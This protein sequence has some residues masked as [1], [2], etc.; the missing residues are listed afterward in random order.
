MSEV[1]LHASRRLAGSSME[2]M[3]TSHLDH[4]GGNPGA[5]RWFLKST[6]NQMLPPEGSICGRLTQDVPRGC[7]QGENKD[8]NDAR[9]VAA[10]G[11]KALIKD[12]H[13]PRLRMMKRSRLCRRR[14]GRRST[15]VNSPWRQPEGK[16]IFYVV[17]SCT[18]AFSKR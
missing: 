2:Q 17:N 18:H 16:Y 15:A 14:G 13:A 8:N 6:L 12:W 7:R 3:C 11:L 4:P 5:N 1:P 9:T 10:R